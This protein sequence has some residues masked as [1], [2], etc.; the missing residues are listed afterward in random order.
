MKESLQKQLF[1]KYPQIFKINN[2]PETSFDYY[3]FENWDGWFK[4]IDLVAGQI[5]SILDSD[6]DSYFNTIQIKQ[7]F[8]RL[9]WHFSC[10]EEHRKE[11]NFIINWAW[12]ESGKICE[13]CGTVENVTQNKSGYILTLC[14]TCR[15]E[16]NK[17]T[18]W[19]D[20]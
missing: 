12:K 7:K 15:D 8:S 9:V 4:L 10:D 3:K 2:P 19:I 5:Q 11:F 16:R 6:K 1:D 14:K 18:E 17:A 20:G 13:Q